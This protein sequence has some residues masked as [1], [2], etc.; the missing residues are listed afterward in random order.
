M[1]GLLTS[2]VSSARDSAAAVAMLL[3]SSGDH[4]VAVEEQ[5]VVARTTRAMDE[6]AAT[7]EFMVG[8][9]RRIGWSK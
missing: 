7:G 3:M 1:P 6:M 9:A 2:M 8:A 5:T 4:S